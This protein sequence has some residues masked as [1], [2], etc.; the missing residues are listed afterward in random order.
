MALIVESGYLVIMCS[1][2]KGTRKIMMQVLRKTR[3][4]FC[5]LIHKNVNIHFYFNF[6]LKKKTNFKEQMR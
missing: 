3:G 1:Q 5:C 4:A 2:S 6:S